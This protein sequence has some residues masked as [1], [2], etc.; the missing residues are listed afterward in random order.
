MLQ[1]DSRN[2][3][4][5]GL[6][7][8]LD[9]N[10]QEG[11]L[12]VSSGRIERSFAL[13]GRS[14][15]PITTS[16]KDRTVLADPLAKL[17]ILEAEEFHDVLESLGNPST[18]GDA[19]IECQL[20]ERDHVLGPL[21][22]LLLEGVHEVFEW[23]A[24]HYRFEAGEIDRSRFLFTD[25]QVEAA[26]AFGVPSIL[27][28]VARREDEWA[29]IRSTIP[30]R[31]QIYRL[32]C[33]AS[34]FDSIAESEIDTLGQREQIRRLLEEPRPLSSLLDEAPAA[35][36]HLLL[37]IRN[38]IEDGHLV[39]LST[40]EKESLAERLR[41]KRQNG[42]LAAVYRSLLEDD[43]LNHEITRRLVLLLEQRHAPHP[44]LAELH[45]RLASHN[46]SSGDQDSELRSLRRRAELLADDVSPQADLLIAIGSSGNR[47]ETRALRNKVVEMGLKQNPSVAAEAIEMT[48]DPD[49][50]EDLT[51]LEKCAELWIAADQPQRA[52]EILKKVLKGSSD[53]GLPLAV[54]HRLARRLEPFDS[55]AAARWLSTA[56]QKRRKS[57][58]KRYALLAVAAV[59]LL[60]IAITTGGEPTPTVLA[61][62]T[63]SIV[64]TDETVSPVAPMAVNRVFTGLDLDRM[65]STGLGLKK[66]GNYQEALEHF[67]GIDRSNLNPEVARQVT[68]ET[69]KLQD[70]ISKAGA[71][72]EEGENHREAGNTAE[73]SKAFRRLLELF[74]HSPYSKGLMIPLV[75]NTYPTDASVLMDG[76][77]AT[78][79]TGSISV[80]AGKSVGLEIQRRGF[81]NA[82]VVIDATTGSRIDVFLQKIP[83]LTVTSEAQVDSRPLVTASRFFTS[84]RN[85]SIDAHRISDGGLVWKHQLDGIGDVL[86]GITQVGDRIVVVTS[87][88]TL[89]SLQ[90]ETG[91]RTAVRSLGKERGLC[92]VAPAFAPD[93]GQVFLVTSRGWIVALD[94]FDFR[95]KWG[96]S[97]GAVDEISPLVT[98]A[99]VAIATGAGEV[100]LLNQENGE[101]LW[102]LPVG[103]RISSLA[104]SGEKLIV[105]THRGAI[106]ACLPG[107]NEIAWTAH[108]DSFISGIAEGAPGTLVVTSITGILSAI[109][110][111]S[112][113]PLWQKKGISGGGTGPL[114]A[115][116]HL[117]SS[118]PEGRINALDPHSG[119][120]LWTF[121]SNGPLTAPMS[122]GAGRILVC[123]H[124]QKAHLLSLQIPL[125]KERF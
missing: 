39:A 92:R 69:E 78:I 94:S 10:R 11:T 63:P 114:L 47:S 103:D 90:M 125:I 96:L 122:A 14:L 84:P 107:S 57:S 60:G 67:K 71:L 45:Q 97:F 70:Y 5:Q 89:Y 112:G 18:P 17:K 105:A 55:K 64:A 65:V 120:L 2:L 3:P 95:E 46:H 82:Q 116:E 83:D 44:E 111:E 68:I 27:M 34:T 4:L 12:T 109:D 16:E 118:S 88:A 117:F 121:H 61:S 37:T 19:L 99:G 42:R 113:S 56:H 106:A 75:L 72:F 9:L 81:E 91:N 108:F 8:S 101:E 93:S 59:I 52:A 86:G 51:W 80:P 77:Q 24:A 20:L 66:E 23:Q 30:S 102:R 36:F 32:E 40:E 31:Y 104:F 35:A 41:N 29:R 119:A 38:L 7:Q 124:H 26:L 110:I 58:E 76:E 73:A 79:E 85:G 1:G 98:P 100:L 48:C 50:R 25:P 6:V 28:E 87:D 15:T 54:I 22:T 21:R 33:D 115:G 49:R 13:T 43:P 123:D 62:P 53:A 74:P